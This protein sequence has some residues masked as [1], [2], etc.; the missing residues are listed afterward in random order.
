MFVQLFKI[1]KLRNV[2]FPFLNCR[3]GLEEGFVE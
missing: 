3:I 1:Q 2:H